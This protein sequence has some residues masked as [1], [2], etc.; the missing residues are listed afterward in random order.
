MSKKPVILGIE[1]SCDE[2]AVAVIREKSIGG[3]EAK[4]IT[5]TEVLLTMH[6]RNIFKNLYGN[7]RV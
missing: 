7:R 2:T 4:T 6:C 1:S 3:A 5:G